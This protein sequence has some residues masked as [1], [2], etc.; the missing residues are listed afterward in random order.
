[1]GVTIEGD[2]GV[3][4]PPES[5]TRAAMRADAMLEKGYM[6]GCKGWR[7]IMEAIEAI[8]SDAIQPSRRVH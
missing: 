8:I 6:E 2:E 4:Q 3:D 5:S 7:W 1:M